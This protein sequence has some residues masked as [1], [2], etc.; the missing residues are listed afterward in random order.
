MGRAAQQ[1]EQAMGKI[2]KAV[3][4]A[5]GAIVA[6]GLVA[7]G[8]KL[9]GDVRGIIEYADHLNDLSKS[10][11]LAIET[12]DGLALAAKQ[13]GADL[14]GAADSINKLSVNIG[15]APE[16][17]RALGITAK[18]PLEAFKQLADIYVKIED[19]QKRAAFAAEALGKSWKTTA[20]LLAEG[21][22]S[23]DAMIQKGHDLSGV[24]KETAEMA[25]KFNDSM[26]EL[27]TAQKGLAVELANDLLPALTKIS[28]E[29]VR[30]YQDGGKLRAVLMGFRQVGG[31]IFGD[32]L[33]TDT[34]KL[35]KINQQVRQLYENRRL[36][37]EISKSPAGKLRD[38]TGAL[39][40]IDAQIAA[41]EAEARALE[42]KIV[43]DGKEPP[44][45]PTD[46]K[47]AAKVDKF[48]GGGAD[49]KALLDGRL[50]AIE[51]AYANERDAIA[52]QAQYMQE[53][54]NQDLIS[55]DEYN[56]GKV[57]TINDGLDAAL[58]AYDKE[59]SELRK[60]RA[61]A[62]EKPERAQLDNQIR[63]RQN[64]KDKARTEAQ[65]ALK[66]N[67]LQL[68]GAQSELNKT[69]KEWGIQQDAANADLEFAN[70]LYGKSLLEVQ[71]LTAARRIELDVEE[72]IRRAKKDGAITDESIER[73]RAAAKAKA[74]AASR[75]M[76][77]GAV[78]QGIESLRTPGEIEQKNHEEMMRILMMGKDGE[79][80]I[81]AGANAALEREN[82]RHQEAMVMI[83]EQGNL[84]NLALAANS[85]GQLYSMLEQAGMEQT[86]L[87]KAV[88]L[89]NKAIAVAEIIMN[90]NVAAAKAQAQL[91]IWGTP[92]A[93]AIRI[94]GYASAGLVAGLAIS[95]AREK[96]GPV[97]AGGEFLVGEKGPELFKP[98]S[99]G[100]IVPNNALGGGGAMKLTIVNNTSAPIGN[101]REVQISP[102][103]RALIIEEAAARGAALTAS[104]LSDPNSPTSRAM[105]RNFS[106]P[107]TR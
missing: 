29:M 9:I 3:N 34:D 71:Q 102:T 62:V 1:T 31:I 67:T 5:K 15:K 42:T 77:Q 98:S 23:I 17:Y 106:V 19:P 73:F 11:G 91:G 53:Q 32:E 12:L 70:S 90:T 83:R 65:Q 10:S 49:A 26:A 96:G 78:Q 103:E 72:Q 18:E 22:K 52:F 4:V 84:Q 55:L 85:A 97:W 64:A 99:G 59:I 21:S 40:A 37:V 50:K 105:G 93:I 82:L 63:D 24:T 107:R 79:F 46:K 36:N 43:A 20:P 94:A 51:N 27:E 38:M 100:T 14:D 89:A 95:G 74:D 88:F 28:E 66:M 47:T 33:D 41:K 57:K 69:M 7:V 56:A 58:K 60:A 54:R 16:K 39:A 76:G 104:N 6:L 25:D 92:A 101:V 61:A 68:S 80:E 44:A 75:F 8:Q 30:G 45:P 48:L 13:S 35:V 86:A 81:V 2:D 87:G